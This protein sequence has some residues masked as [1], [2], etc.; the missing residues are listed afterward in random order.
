VKPS[1][2]FS[3]VICPVSNVIQLFAVYAGEKNPKMYTP[4]KQKHSTELLE[5]KA[6][7]NQQRPENKGLFLL[8]FYS[9]LNSVIKEEEYFNKLEIN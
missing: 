6:F 7:E 2:Y 8:D 9:V 4:S 5:K 1:S 3:R